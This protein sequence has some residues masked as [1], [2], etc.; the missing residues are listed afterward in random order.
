CIA[1]SKHRDIPGPTRRLAAS[2]PAFRA[3][4]GEARSFKS[5]E[6][7]PQT[8]INPA[9]GKKKHPPTALQVAHWVTFKEDQRLEWQKDY[10]RRLCEAD[11][12]IQETYELIQEFTTLL[13]ERKGEQFDSWL[14]RVEQQGGAELQSF[15]ASAY[16][17]TTM[18]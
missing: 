6:P 5:V 4:K 8:M 16:A 15:A 11:T 1:R 7:T 2:S 14:A 9:E 13:R 10:L 17:K 3:L 18:P 12:H